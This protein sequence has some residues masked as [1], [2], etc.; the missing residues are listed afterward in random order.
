MNLRLAPVTGIPEIAA[1]DDLATIVGNALAAGAGDLGS[2]RDGDIV[3]VAQKIVS[4]AEGRTVRPAELTPGPRAIELAAL[5]EKDAVVVQ[6]ILNESASVLRTA[7]GVLIVET[8][9]GFVCANAGVDRSNLPDGESLLLLPVDPDASARGLWRSLT[10]RFGIRLG[11]VVTDSFG[12]AWR[13]GQTDV[14]IGCAGLRPLLDIRG[15]QDAHGQALTATI[16]AVADELAGAANLARRKNSLEPVVLI[17]GREDIITNDE[18]CGVD[19]LLREKSRD[20]FR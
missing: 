14:A 9:H 6:A 3:V 5:T 18:G 20:L 4:K 2:P 12:R 13:T 11:V 10:T 15:E 7:P 16:D 17:R 8:H 19:D 1:G